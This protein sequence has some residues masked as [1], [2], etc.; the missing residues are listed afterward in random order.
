MTKAKMIDEQLVMMI[1][2]EYHPF[3]IVEDKEFRKLINMCPSYS[4]PSI[5]TVTQNLLPQMY[6]MTLECV[7]DKK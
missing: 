4:I 3:S 1:V 6:E 2:K 5:K 7:K